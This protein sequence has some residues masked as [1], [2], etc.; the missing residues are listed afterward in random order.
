MKVINLTSLTQAPDFV[1]LAKRMFPGATLKGVICSASKVE[2]VLEELKS[3]RE[4]IVVLLYVIR[5]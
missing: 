5:K 1:I 4:E 3:R 2:L